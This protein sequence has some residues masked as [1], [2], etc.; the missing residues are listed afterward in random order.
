MQIKSNPFKNKKIAVIGDICLDKFTEGKIER[1]NPEQPA[2]SLVRIEKEYYILGAAANVANNISALG[3][4]C[5]LYGVLGKDQNGE[6]FK[7]LCKKNKI[8]LK[9]FKSNQKTTLKQRLVADGYQVA[10]MDFG[11][12]NLHKID[13]KLQSKIFSKLKKDIKKIDVLVLSDYNKIIFTKGFSQKIIKLAN[14][15]NIKTVVDPKPENIDFFKD[16]TIICPNKKES[17]NITQIRYLKEE[18]SIS[19]IV[20]KMKEKTNSKYIVM[21]CG[22]DGVVGYNPKN[23]ELSIIETRARTVRDVTGAGDTFAAVL[24]LGFVSKFSFKEILNIANHAAGLVVEKQ[25]TATINY[26]ELFENLK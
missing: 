3:S 1:I 9:S 8:I 11:E 25:G 13:I 18:K 20:K 21:T 14:K 15:H 24:A 6:I 2:A 10:R 23:D 22:E 12:N 17:E 7:N 16:C 5:T 4:P 19:N 26:K